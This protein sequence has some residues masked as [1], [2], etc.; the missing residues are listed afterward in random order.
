MESH[1]L[2]IHFI[3]LTKK[4]RFWAAEPS[5]CL[6]PHQTSRQMTRGLIK[7]PKAAIQNPKIENQ[8]NPLD[9]IPTSVLI[10]TNWP[11]QPN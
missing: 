7:A 3:P 2:Q 9:R 5:S 6:N 8:Q 1:G 4:A 11:Q 10:L